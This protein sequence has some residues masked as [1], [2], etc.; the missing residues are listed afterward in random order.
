MCC[1]C[2]PHGNQSRVAAERP[3]SLIKT[4]MQLPGHIARRSVTHINSRLFSAWFIPKKPVVL[5][6]D[7]LALWAFTPRLEVEND[8]Q[9][10]IKVLTNGCFGEIPV[11]HD[12]GR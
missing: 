7:I 3:R 2:T 11:R 4:S 9:E 6:T 10:F 12:R 5:L 8:C 1:I